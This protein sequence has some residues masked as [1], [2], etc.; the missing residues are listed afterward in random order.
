MSAPGTI[1][2]AVEDLRGI[3]RLSH[4]VRHRHGE[5]PYGQIDIITNMDLMEITRLAR[6]GYAKTG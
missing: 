2:L 1:T 3:L 6:E 5:I 4:E